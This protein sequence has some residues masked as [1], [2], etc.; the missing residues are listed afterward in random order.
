MQ[1]QNLCSLGLNVE[2]D[3]FKEL[4]RLP[5]DLADT[6]AQIFEHFKRLG[7]ESRVIAERS[8]KWLLCQAREFSEAEFLASVSIG[9]EPRSLNLTKETILFICGN[10]VM[11]DHE[12]K[13]FRFVHL[14]V[15]EYLETQPNFTLGAAHALGAEISL[16]I[17]LHGYTELAAEYARIL[18]PYAFLY[19][20][21][22]CQETKKSGLGGPLHQLLEE[23]LHIRE[24]ANLYYATWARSVHRLRSSRGGKSRNWSVESN[25][26]S[27][28]GTDDDLIKGILKELRPSFDGALKSGSRLAARDLEEDKILDSILGD[29]NY[30]YDPTLAAC[31][32]GLPEIVDQNLQSVLSSPANEMEDV[33][34]DNTNVYERRNV[35]R[36]TYLHVACHS[37]SSKVLQLLLQYPFSVCS[38][39][40]WGRTALHYAVDSHGLASLES[41]KRTGAARDAHDQAMAA[42]R[43]AM[44]GLLIAKGSIIDAVD[45][46]GRTALQRASSANRCTEAQFLLEHGAFVD[47]PSPGRSKTQV[48]EVKKGNIA[49]LW[50]GT[51]PLLQAAESGHT[52]V[53]QLLLQFKADIEARTKYGRTP[54]LQAAKSGHTD[55]AQLLLQF[56]AD[57]EARDIYQR[58]PL[59]QAAKSGRTA[60]ARLLLQFKADTEARDSDQKT[61]LLQAIK[62][63]DTAIAQLLLQS[64]ADIEAR[65]QY[66]RTP[67]LQAAMKGN[68]DTG[69]LLLRH[70]A[71]IN[72]KN[73]DN[74]TPLAESLLLG[75]E[76]MAQML[77]DESASI[78][79]LDLSGNTALHYAA[80]SRLG[81]T[82]FRLLEMGAYT[83]ETYADGSTPLH[84]AIKPKDSFSKP[85]DRT[86]EAFHPVQLLIDAGANVEM[87][88]NGGR[89][90]LHLAAQEAD[91]ASVQILLNR[92][93]NTEARD[94]MGRLPLDHA[95]K[96]GS[97][98]VFSLLFKRWADVMAES[99]EFTIQAWLHLADKKARGDGVEIL[100][101][102]RT[103]SFEDLIE[104]TSDC[105]IQRN[106][107]EKGP[108]GFSSWYRARQ[109]VRKMRAQHQL[110][111]AI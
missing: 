43:V 73:S 3:L 68:T 80:A 1:L 57:I 50:F 85:M 25:D 18:R 75:H 55:V 4:G 19:W 46:S 47:A 82:I 84:R 69:R 20:L 81:A 96:S 111:P 70:G 106:W 65:D 66:G 64:R 74:R 104:L 41:A 54:L 11:F 17:C 27:N 97:L 35:K 76:A 90:P 24:G 10:L 101:N 61:P 52:G 6:Y 102:W 48:L 59:L 67:L 95:A 31:Y 23:F 12:L 77:I 72:A 22:H 79:G 2:E 29:R 39:D 107:S 16:S 14:S 15:R 108:R 94:K 105:E 56:K 63:G 21:H 51:T 34:S 58:T 103:M 30:P 8:L 110:Q 98:Q 32:L 45:D 93:A 42:E 100:Q 83:N 9:T 62:S 99:S 53:A 71:D 87:S 91:K 33:A 44:I 109:L 60:V 5:G 88:D 7:P 78:Q 92:G 26:D 86:D 40:E 37:G 28:D 13:V 38:T 49:M 89:T 36:Q